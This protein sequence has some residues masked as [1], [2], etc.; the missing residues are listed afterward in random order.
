MSSKNEIIEEIEKELERLNSIMLWAPY[1]ADIPDD[2]LYL[3]EDAGVEAEFDGVYCNCSV[4]D[5]KVVYTQKS[6]WS[7]AILWKDNNREEHR[8]CL[9]C[10][11]G[12]ENLMNFLKRMDDIKK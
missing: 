5:H 3:L 11:R 7:V 4:V 10:M 12:K 2:I 9:T 8:I 6:S 1:E